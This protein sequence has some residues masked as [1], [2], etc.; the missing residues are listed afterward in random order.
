MKIGLIEATLPQKMSHIFYPLG[1]GYIASYVRKHLPGVE[2]RIFRSIE[3]LLDFEPDLVGISCM[4]SNYEEAVNLSALIREKLGAPV[5]LGGTHISSIPST[6]PSSC[7]AGVIGEGEQ[8]FLEIIELFIKKG[9]LPLDDLKKIDGLVIRRGDEIH[10][11]NP[12]KLIED[13]NQIPFP[14]RDIEGCYYNWS[15]TSRGCPY[16]CSFCYSS[17]FWDTCRMNSPS[18]VVDE[19]KKLSKITDI[20]YHTF[21]DDLFGAD[22]ERVKKIARLVKER[23]SDPI[24]FTATARANMVDERLCKVYRNL[25]VKFIH[26][27][28]ESG[29]DRILKFLKPESSSVKQNQ[30]ALDLLHQYGLNSIGTFIVGCFEE[31][32]EDLK[33]TC[34]FIERNVRSG[35]L[36][37]FSF[38]PLLPF[39]GTRVW[40]MGVG[41]GLIK[42]EKF[43]WKSLDIDVRNFDRERYTLLT[44]KIGKDRFYYYF[45]KLK[46]M[47]DFS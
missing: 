28:L 44:D 21:L 27:G 5:V 47:M 39:P 34:D 45:E 36:H 24:V 13:V 38:G 14:A 3:K 22:L 42:P 9:K 16:N 1:Q 8:T 19:L 40:E 41:R 6:L 15:M 12:R 10:C 43:D 35:K 32:E 11:T 20:S 33:L 4:S 30:R 31:T 7:A 37:S 46:S 25:G 29:S 17:L 2:V 23:F 26:L 18:Y